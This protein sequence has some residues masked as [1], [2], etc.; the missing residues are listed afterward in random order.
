[1]VSERY[2]DFAPVSDRAV[3][4]A[5]QRDPA[6]AAPECP[7]ID[8]PVE[9]GVQLPIDSDKALMGELGLPYE[10]MG[11]ESRLRGLVILAHGGGSSR[12]S[13]RNRFMAGWLRMA[14]WATLRVDL[15]LPD[16]QAVDAEY[17]VHRFDVA[18]IGQRLTVAI[19]WAVREGIPGSA[20]IVLCGASTGA[21]AAVVAAMERPH[22]VTG[23]VA[24]GG[25]VDL[26]AAA[27]TLLRIPILMVVGGDDLETLRCG[28]SALR[29]LRGDVTL[30]VVPGAGHVFEES[31]AMGAAVTQTI[32]WLNRRQPSGNRVERYATGGWRRIITPQPSPVS[33]VILPLVRRVLVRRRSTLSLAVPATGT[34]AAEGSGD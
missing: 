19:D 5:P 20:N 22:D 18:L 16:E 13:F 3:L 6:D 14:G 4:R 11:P 26:A 9:C 21:A 30:K 7:T 34:T 33:A 12:Q 27:L 23:I 1:M 31:G 2:Q 10:W 8:P 25:R 29:L 17:G 28:R 15:L 32:K 24:L